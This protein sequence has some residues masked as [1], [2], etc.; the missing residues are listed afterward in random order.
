M[1]LSLSHCFKAVPS[2]HNFNPAAAWQ[3]VILS[4][5]WSELKKTCLTWNK[6]NQQIINQ[7]NNLE[8]SEQ[9]QFSKIQ[10]NLYEQIFAS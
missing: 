7:A 9:Y 1:H 3:G 10:Q 6:E 4:L 5:D 8:I 2:H